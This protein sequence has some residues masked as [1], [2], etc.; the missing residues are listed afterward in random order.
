MPDHLKNQMEV[1]SVWNKKEE[2]ETLDIPIII[3]HNIIYTCGD[4]FLHSW[5]EL[6]KKLSLV[7]KND[8]LSEIFARCAVS[9]FEIIELIFKP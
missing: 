5:S 7:A 8:F 1:L 4:F 6:N 9:G 3:I 2:Y